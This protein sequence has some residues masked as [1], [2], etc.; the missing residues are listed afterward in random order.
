MQKTNLG[1]LL[2][3]PLTWDKNADKLYIKFKTNKT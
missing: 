1:Q 2:T 3:N